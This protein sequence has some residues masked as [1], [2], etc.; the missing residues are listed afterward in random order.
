MR[1]GSSKTSTNQSAAKL[2]AKAKALASQKARQI[3]QSKLVLRALGAIRVTKVVVSPSKG[4][5]IG[6]AVGAFVVLLLLILGL[7]ALLR[8][9][10]G[11]RQAPI[12]PAPAVPIAEP[13]VERL[14]EEAHQP[15]A[16]QPSAQPLS[17]QPAP[18]PEPSARD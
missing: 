3:Q 11:S 12:P 8:G 18:A 1:A 15:T 2:A 6:Y 14:D 7:D 5:A 10:G 9:S 17:A 16:E 13:P 4:K